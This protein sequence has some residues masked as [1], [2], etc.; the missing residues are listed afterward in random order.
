MVIR[1]K[2]EGLRQTQP[3]T[4]KRADNTALNINEMREGKVLLQSKPQRLVFELTNMCNLNCVM[5]GRNAT[6]FTSTFFKVEWFYRFQDVFC[7]IEEITLMGWGEPTIHPHFSEMLKIMHHAGLRKY[8][9]TNGMRLK[10]LEDDIFNYEVDIIAISMDGAD[11]ETNAKIRRGADF[12]KIITALRSIAARK[13]ME[14]LMWPHMNFVFTAMKSNIAQLPVVVDLA[15]DIGLDEVKV[16]FLTVFSPS[17]LGESLYNES[18]SVKKYFSEANEIAEKNNILLKLP[19]VKGTDPAGEKLH[20]D[21]F[22]AYRDFFLGSDGYI[23]ACMSS[24]EK[25]FHIDKYANF[26]NMWNSLEHQSWRCTVNDSKNMPDACK[27]CYQSSYA[28]WNKEHAFM[29]IV[30][31]FAPEWS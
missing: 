11:N 23:R 3:L 20:K 18:E 2:T 28:N 16:V 7:S 6:N 12:N 13:K 31:T 5:C 30:E 22:T 17:L 9:C 10:E 4:K 24:P 21:C 27:R 15:A 1:A 29:Q 19:H 8:F 25:L 14:N 26:N